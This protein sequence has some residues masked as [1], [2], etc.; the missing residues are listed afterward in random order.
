[1]VINYLKNITT[2][3]LETIK[4]DCMWIY[5]NVDLDYILFSMSILMLIYKSI[6]VILHTT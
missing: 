1:M 4:L 3:I 6:L 5:F 2:F